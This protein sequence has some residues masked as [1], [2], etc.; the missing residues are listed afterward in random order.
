MRSRLRALRLVA[1]DVDGVLSDGGM[2]YGPD[3]EGLKR[4]DVKDGLGLR[5]LREAGL[6]LALISGENSRIVVRRAEKLRIEEVHLGVE[7]KAAV[8]L[9]LLARHGVEP[10]HAAYLGDDLNDLGPLGV[11]GVAGAPADAVPEVLRAAHWVSSR[12]GGH[13]AVREFCDAVL[14]ARR[15]P[16]KPAPRRVR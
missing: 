11:A 1:L 9:D 13:G 15:I 7:D 2:Y 16:L 5:R 6:F 4:F 14:A 10:A 8:F 3:G 12:P